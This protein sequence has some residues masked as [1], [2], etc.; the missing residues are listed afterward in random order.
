MMGSSYKGTDYFGSGPHRFKVGRLGR[1]VI[2]LAA[3]AGDASVDGAAEFG[4]LEPRIEVRGRLVA[5]TE[6][7]LWALRDALA[8]QA[9]S[10]VG[11]G[12]L[13][14]PHGH[15]WEDMK[16]LTVEEDGPVA[17]G[18]RVSVGYAAVFGRLAS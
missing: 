7:G 14:D 15:V 18:R 11:A 4:D 13:V 1:R 8:A 6:A 3:I 2:S 12:D 16:L 9:D 5:D 17:R 10:G